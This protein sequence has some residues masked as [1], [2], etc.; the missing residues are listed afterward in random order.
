MEWISQYSYS[1][2]VPWTYKNR[3]PADQWP[4]DN[5]MIKQYRMIRKCSLKWGWLAGVLLL[6]IIISI[7]LSFLIKEP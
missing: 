4:N 3:H 1:L 7:F 6:C 5:I 2:L